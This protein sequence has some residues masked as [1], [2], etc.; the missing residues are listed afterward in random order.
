MAR[1]LNLTQGADHHLIRTVFFQM[2]P[3]LLPPLKH[4]YR[5]AFKHT[6]DRRLITLD[7]VTGSIIIS[8]GDLAFRTREFELADLVGHESVESS[9]LERLRLALGTT[10]SLLL[11]R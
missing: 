11:P 9:F 7:I 3:Q 2:L 10:V 4:F 5:L 6:W 8:V 1:K